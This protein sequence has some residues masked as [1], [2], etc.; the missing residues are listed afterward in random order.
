MDK[1]HRVETTVD[2]RVLPSWQYG[3]FIICNWWPTRCNFLFIY[4]YPISSTCFGRYLRPSSGAL[5]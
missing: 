5:D 4:L 1:D 2:M 3:K